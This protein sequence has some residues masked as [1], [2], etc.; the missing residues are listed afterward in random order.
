MI[1]PDWLNERQQ[2]VFEYVAKELAGGKIVGNIDVFI[3]SSFAVAVDRLEQIEKSIN[4]KPD[5]MFDKS[6]LKAKARYT[7]DFNTGIKELSLSP[8]ARAKLGGINITAEKEKVDPVLKIME[9]YRGS[10]AG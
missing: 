4:S 6:L 1:P 9:K 7:A 2:Q 8:Q 10:G 5:M 3:L